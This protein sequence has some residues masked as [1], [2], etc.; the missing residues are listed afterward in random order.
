MTQPSLKDFVPATTGTQLTLIAIRK[1]KEEMAILVEELGRYFPSPSTSS[2]SSPI[3]KHL[4]TEHE[5]LSRTFP[6]NPAMF[7]QL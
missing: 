3:S 5:H 4:E 2:A 6:S 7:M 1:E